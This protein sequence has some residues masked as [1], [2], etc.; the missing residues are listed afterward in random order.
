M[1]R[2]IKFHTFHFLFR[3][4]A[5]LAD[6]SGGW[7]VFVRPKLLLGS[8]I[9]G[10]GLISSGFAQ[11]SNQNK[12]KQK[13]RQT[14][15]NKKIS[16]GD[17]IRAKDDS[18]VYA[19]ENMITDIKGNCRETMEHTS[20]NNTYTI[21]EQ[22]PLFPEG[23]EALMKYISENIKYPIIAQENGI[24]GKVICRF[25]VTSKGEIDRIEILRSLDP[26]CDKE[27]VRL[28]KTLP[29][30]IPAKRNGVSV[31]VWYTLPINFKLGNTQNETMY[32]PPKTNFISS[33]QDDDII[34]PHEFIDKDSI[35]ES[36]EDW[37]KFPGGEFALF[38][39]INENIKYPKTKTNIRGKVIVR[40][41]ITK[42]G[43]IGRSEILQSLGPAFD[44]EAIRVVKSLPKWT[45]GK[46]KGEYINVW[47]N[48]PINFMPNQAD[49]KSNN[50]GETLDIYES[51]KQMP[52]FPGGEKEL[53]NY[54]S[55]ELVYPVSAKQRGI[56][57]NVYVRFVVTKTGT[58]NRIEV[59][60]PLTP[61]CDAEAIRF[62]KKFPTWIP[63]KLGDKSVDVYYTIALPFKPEK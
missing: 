41:E 31:S 60:R 23:E 56:Q 37:P 53:S 61:D 33:I 12:A 39:Y 58:L 15:Q 8:L 14:I 6:K 27:S 25:I 34:D 57:G 9:V 13:T 40:F 35:Y 21:V 2:K 49:S 29:K 30:F 44:Y 32:T 28:I 47:Y 42:T 62:V 5:Y 38:T 51:V 46:H 7:W 18:V 55:K 17:S 3:L 52:Q 45:P 10:L 36:I 1:S 48:I 22:M 59:V 26:S 50:S 11:I 16:K 54:I 63:G 4:F 20:Q 24:Q 19:T 43:E